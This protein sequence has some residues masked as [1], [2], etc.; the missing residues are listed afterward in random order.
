MEFIEGKHFKDGGWFDGT[1]YVEILLNGIWTRVDAEISKEYPKNYLSAQGESFETYTFTFDKLSDCD[2]VR[3]VG[4]PGGTAYFISVGEIT[5]ICENKQEFGGGNDVFT[6]CSVTAPQGGGSKDLSVIYDGKK[7]IN[8]ATQYDTYRKDSVAAEAYVG[9]LYTKERRVSY[10]EFTEGG[11]FDD[12][13]WFKNGD[14]RVELY[15]DGE[16]VSDEISVS[17]AYPKGDEKGIFGKNY[18]TYIFAL[19][20]P[21]ECRGVRIIGAAGGSAGFISVSEITVK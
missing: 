14:I 3:I 8:S 19:K 18:E 6:I 16:W 13:G 15:I 10:I 17:P 4:K 20:T 11:H 5:P 7:G 9:Y 21:T 1:P 12:G 2:G